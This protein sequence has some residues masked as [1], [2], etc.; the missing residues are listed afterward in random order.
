MTA[1]LGSV[2]GLGRPPIPAPS[3]TPPVALLARNTAQSVPDSPVSMMATAPMVRVT[4]AH[5]ALV[6]G[7]IDA[8]QTSRALELLDAV[9]HPRVAEEQVW[10]LRLWILAVEGRILEALDLARLAGRELPGSAAVAYLQAALEHA[11]DTPAAALES[12]L[13]AQTLAPDH[14]LPAALVALLSARAGTADEDA[15]GRAEPAHDL[16]PQVGPPLGTTGA[17][18]PNPIAAAQVGAGLL[19]PLGSGQPLI[20]LRSSAAPATNPARP[21]RGEGRRFGVIAIATVVSALWAIR[22]PVPAAVVLALTV[23]WTIRSWRVQPA[24]RG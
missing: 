13:R 4:P 11:S 24:G 8:G 5:L 3:S 18:L 14:P 20:P 23:G 1:P 15:R 7:L 6:R 9:W 17:V 22:D 12:A 21:L 19:Y 16:S 10:Y 2:R